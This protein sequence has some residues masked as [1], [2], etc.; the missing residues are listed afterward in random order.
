MSSFKIQV[1]DDRG[2]SVP[3]CSVGVYIEQGITGG[4]VTSGQ[5][6]SY[7]WVEFDIPPHVVRRPTLQAIY[8]EGKEV[9]S[10]LGDL[11]DGDTF[12]VTYPN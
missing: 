6:D 12:S 5:T 4:G 7:G 9:A 3:G 11:H 10:Y 1:V 8:V 2:V